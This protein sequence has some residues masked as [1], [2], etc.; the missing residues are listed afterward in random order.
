M[1]TVLKLSQWSISISSW[2]REQLILKNTAKIKSIAHYF[3][4]LWTLLREK[5]ANEREKLGKKRWN[6]RT[7]S[8]IATHTHKHIFGTWT[9]FLNAMEM[10]V[11]SQHLCSCIFQMKSNRIEPQKNTNT[12]AENTLQRVTKIRTYHIP[13]SI[14]TEFCCLAGWMRSNWNDMETR[15]EN[16]DGGIAFDISS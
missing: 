8:H 13:N 9:N 2:I 10:T 5:N 16:Y 14:Y 1:W 7:H 12:T 3:R 4:F 11:W 6:E 15:P